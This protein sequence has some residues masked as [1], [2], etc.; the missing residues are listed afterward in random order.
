MRLAIVCSILLAASGVAA[1]ATPIFQ[2]PQIII[3]TGGDAIG[4]TMGINQV[5]PCGSPSCTYDFFN[6]TGGIVTSFLFDTTIQSRLSSDVIS[7]NFSCA[8]PG[9]YFL[10][11][12]TNY[13]SGTGDL[14]YVFSGVGKSDG[15]EGGTDSEAGEMEGIPPGG[16]FIITLNGWV[17]NDAL[18]VGGAPPELTNSFTTDAPEPSAALLFGT[19]ITMLLAAFLFRRSSTR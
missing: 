13:T 7:A 8:D 14:Q 16:H 6:D 12:S 2:D 11:C 17:E 5:E 18:F 3:D 9:G 15:D 19:G 10:G 4:I 1:M